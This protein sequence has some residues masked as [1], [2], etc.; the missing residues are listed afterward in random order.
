MID[1]LRQLDMFEGVDDAVLEEFVRLGEERRLEV[2][3]PLLVEGEA[4]DLFWV[5]AEGRIEWSRH[6]AVA[7]DGEA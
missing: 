6:K 5:I 3:Q 2:G 1:V 4:P 7:A